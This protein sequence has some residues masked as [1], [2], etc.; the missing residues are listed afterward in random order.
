L[1]IPCFAFYTGRHKHLRI[2]LLA[3]INQSRPGPMDRAL[4]VATRSKPIWEAGFQNVFN[5]ATAP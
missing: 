2:P 5:E 1:K 4:I 3:P